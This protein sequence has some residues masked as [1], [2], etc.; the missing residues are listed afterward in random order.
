MDGSPDPDHETVE[1]PRAQPLY[2]QVKALMMQRLIAGQWRP[3]EM[4]PS[5]FQLADE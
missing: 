5:E 3:G 1:A 2:A 4:L